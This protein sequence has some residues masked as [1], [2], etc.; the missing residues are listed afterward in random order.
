MRTSRSSG[1]RIAGVLGVALFAAISGGMRGTS[2][3]AA[4][5]NVSPAAPR[6]LYLEVYINDVSTGL[7]GKFTQLADGTLVATVEELREVGLRATDSARTAEGLVRLD[8]LPNVGVRIDEPTQRLFVTSTDEA[9]VP[10]S[11]DAGGGG[12]TVDVKPQ[13]SFGAVLNYSLLAS[14]NSLVDQN[15]KLFQGLAGSYD[16]RLFSPFGTISQ[17]F[18]TNYSNSPW[19]RFTRLNTSWSYSDPESLITYR[20]GDLISGG[21]PWTRP[22]Y[23]GGFQVQRNF[24]LR[25]DLVTMPLPSF[26]GTAAVPSTVEI[27]SHNTRAY[28]G[29]LAPGPFRIDNLPVTAGA[30]EARVVLRDSL[31]QETVADLP[32]YASSR[33]LREGLLDF[34]TELG[35]PRRNFG[36]ESDDYDGRLM[37]AA[38]ARYGLTDWLTLEGHV[39]GGTDL[40][41]GGLGVAFPLGSFGVGSFAA[42]ASEYNGETGSLINASLELQLERWSLFGRT[43]RTFGQYEDIGSITAIQN[44]GRNAPKSFHAGVPRTLDQVTLSVPTPFEASSLSLLFTNLEYANGDTSRIAGISYSQQLFERSTFFS[45]G[46]KDFGSHGGF[47]LFAGISV[48]LGG[49]I[50][51]TTA[52]DHGRN[53][54]RLVTDVA[55]SERL[56]N[57]S[58]AW[59]LHSSEGTTPDRSVA[60]SYRAPVARMEVGVQ[61]IGEGLRATGQL[62]GALV[63][64]GGGVFASNRID[65]AFAVVDVGAPNVEVLHQNR[66]VGKTDR[67]GRILVPGLNAY[68]P[69][70]IS[71]DPS[72][73]PVDTDIASTTQVVVPADR[74]GVVADFG[75]DTSPSAALVR[76]V[77]GR[78]NPLEAGVQGHLLTGSGGEFV[79]G[80]D[81]EA[82]LRQLLAQNAVEIDRLD[83]TTCSARFEFQA[84]RGQQVV[85]ED[86]P[87]V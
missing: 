7:I 13:S 75:V 68:E 49:D 73:L 19:D 70:T 30:G 71:I 81:G 1:A 14:T 85:V 65:D 58:V 20:G 62:D 16:A 57:G 61:Q 41:N 24:A 45:T 52:L 40:H 48:P 9:R 35:Y 87:C 80:Y 69:N 76:F 66:H 64:A 37:G 11:I 2:S 21:L 50:S 86:V 51:A 39:E 5:P 23:L 77:D 72:N 26:S 84:V 27:Y 67:H 18:T 59:R 17:S 28:S 46:F 63:L 36:I 47:G 53:G 33:L 3:A 8:A 32:F 79:I 15:V 38:T 29:D 31:S 74:S 10:R 54:T 12:S 56:E 60:V 83:G 82:Y 4:E 6:D 42:A 43:Q 22:V 78:G 55:R 25:P 44:T 34:S